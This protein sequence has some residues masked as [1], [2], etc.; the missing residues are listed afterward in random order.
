MTIPQSTLWPIKPHTFAKH[1][2][3]KK[4]LQAWFPIIDKSFRSLIYF[5]GFCGPGRYSG[6]ERGSPII[7]L[8]E[9]VNHSSQLT[10][11]VQFLFND[12]RQD[13]IDNLQKECKDIPLP[14]NFSV[15][16]ENKEFKYNLRDV[17]E[18]YTPRTQ[19]PTFVLVDPFGFTGIPFALISELM[20][21]QGCE[22]LITF[23]AESINR[24]FD[25]SDA[26]IRAGIIETFGSD[27][28]VPIALSDSG[29]RI[30]QLRDLYQE[31][32]GSIAKYTRHFEMRKADNCVIYYLFFISNHRLGYIKMKEAMWKVAPN[33]AFRFS[34]ATDPNQIV[35]FSDDDHWMPEAK[36]FINQRF[37]GRTKVNTKEIRLYIED[38]TPFLSPH[39]KAA[40]R[41]M[42]ADNNIKVDEKKLNG[43]ARRKNSFPDGVVVKF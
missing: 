22:C 2:I 33:G 19:P 12:I 28:G 32:M 27:K 42:E 4:Y 8:E 17:L 13:R 39:M 34:D 26:K 24:F 10:G 21:R 30:E 36:R 6:G 20:A 25:L 9:A 43:K 3:L 14:S 38:K 40:L 15:S 5:D 31:Q 1:S 29:S 37:K 16:V 11:D 18:K 23:M 41:E 7:A 35:L